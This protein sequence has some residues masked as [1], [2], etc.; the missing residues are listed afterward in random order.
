MMKKVYINIVLSAI[1]LASA[2]CNFLDKNPNLRTEID[3][4]KKVQLLLVNAYDAPNY[5]P[6]GEFCSDN[7]VDNNTP[8]G[9]TKAAHKTPLSQMMSELFAWQDVTSDNSQDSP[10]YIWNFCYKNIAVANQALD[11]I[12]KLEEEG[13]DMSA[14]KAEALLCRAY[15]HFILVNIFC[16]AYKDPES[17]K[18]DIGIH[19]MT[20][21]EN[22]VKPA[23]DRGN[24]AEVYRL[25]EED[26][27]AALPLVSD[28]YY[29]VPKYHFNV[30]AAYAFAARFY[31]FIRDYDK[32]ITYANRVLGS[33][34]SEA[35]SKMFDADNCMKLGNIEQEMYAWYDA[36]SP[37]NL[38]LQTTY[39]TAMYNFLADYCRYT[40]NRAP[41]DYT[42]NGSGPCWSS[43]FP[44]VNI[45]RF[46]DKFGGF[47]AK[48]YE[49]FEYTNKEAGIGYPHSLRREFTTGETLLCRAEAKIMKGDLESAAE[50]MNTWAKGYL[51]TTTLT[52][53]KITQFFARSNGTSDAAKT[54]NAQLVPDLHNEDMCS[55]WVISAD[56]RPYI[57]CVLHFR[58]IET[59]HDGMRWFD[60]KR[61]GIELEHEISDGVGGVVTKK[62][63]W[64]DDRRAIQLPQEAI[65]GGQT[66]N[67]R[68]V[69]GDNINISTAGSESGGLLDL[70]IKLQQALSTLSIMD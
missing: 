6:I 25:I 46:D 11:A 20:D 69:V 24:V 59:L 50:D 67:P 63:I 41:R 29:S 21:I 70:Y 3:S 62:L 52:A 35:L 43:R 12:K 30:S 57:W 68:N 61:Y 17:S 1:L 7:I 27:Q 45:W 54:R 40:F 66:K 55:D 33:S 39:S 42:V 58:R 36:S 28:E 56:K 53:D 31:L 49:P 23:Y 37:A 48:V 32:V 19:Y 26:I 22:T 13:E 34:S 14:E 38:F 51:C 8:W 16:Q 5:G 15:N 44:G 65:E 2:G 47:L 4:K 60:I 18:Q 10:Y 9:D 64:N